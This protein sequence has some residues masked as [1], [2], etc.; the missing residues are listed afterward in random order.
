M[1][2]LS[3]A[4]GGRNLLPKS[5]TELNGLEPTLNRLVES[6]HGKEER[7][8]GKGQT[9]NARAISLGKWESC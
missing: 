8:Y 6:W 5:L 9:L 2:Y 3:T 7:M 1:G 4:M